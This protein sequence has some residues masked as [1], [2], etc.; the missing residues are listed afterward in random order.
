MADSDIRIDKYLWAIRIFKTRSIAAEAIKK[1]RVSIDGQTVKTSRTIKVGQVID[2]KFP[3][4]TRSFK[5]LALSGKR[6]GAK[7]VPD[8]MTEVTTPEQMELI[9]IQKLSFAMGRRKGLG[10]PTK[11]DRRELDKWEE[12]DDWDF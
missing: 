3:P 10:R 6:M 7:L 2:I 5:V 8:F 11:K 1:G 12:Q 4:V 9:E